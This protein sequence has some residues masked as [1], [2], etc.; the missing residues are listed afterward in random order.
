MCTGASM[1]YYRLIF[2]L[3]VNYLS[4]VERFR[5][6][7]NR[8]KIFSSPKIDDAYFEL[9]HIQRIASN[10]VWALRYSP[11]GK[12][13]NSARSLVNRRRT[14]FKVR[15]YCLIEFPDSE[16]QKCVYYREIQSMFI[17]MKIIMFLGENH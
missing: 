12:K 10:S 15:V 1:A 16:I 2:Q 13:F 5:E 14:N 3:C 6:Q 8:D 11:N 7:K 17:N 4:K 9:Q